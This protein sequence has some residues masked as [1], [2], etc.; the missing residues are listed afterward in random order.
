MELH[1][2]KGVSGARKK[3]CDSKWRA[4]F[5]PC[6]CRAATWLWPPV[7]ARGFNFSGFQC[8][9]LP[10]CPCD[11]TGNETFAGINT[12]LLP[13]CWVDEAQQIE[14]CFANPL[15][16][17]DSVAWRDGAHV[18]KPPKSIGPLCRLRGKGA[19][20]LCRFCSPLAQL[21]SASGFACFE[22]G[23]AVGKGHQTHSFGR[24]FAQPRGFWT[25]WARLVRTR[26]K[27][28]DSA[29]A[30]KIGN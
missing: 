11:E 28:H 14:S 25:I 1:R 6:F 4:L 30:K 24:G 3:V 18:L 27:T 15:S 22:G 19:I 2:Q 21:D 8:W 26:A 5:L 16:C 29:D 12:G 23:F 10:V 9:F 17:V 7:C 20:G 13:A